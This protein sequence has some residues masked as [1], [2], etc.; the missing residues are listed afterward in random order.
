MSDFIQN[1]ESDISQ[2]HLTDTNNASEVPTSQSALGGQTR[3]NR[4]VE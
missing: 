4:S 1:D 3:G 2:M